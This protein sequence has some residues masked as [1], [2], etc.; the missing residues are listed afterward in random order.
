MGE[1]R[2]DKRRERDAQSV[3]SGFLAIRDSRWRLQAVLLT[4]GC[5]ANDS[6]ASMFS[7]ALPTIKS[8][9][10][11]VHTARIFCITHFMIFIARVERRGWKILKGVNTL[12]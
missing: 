9:G 5:F 8:M 11:F 4:T 7:A 10:S 12:I 1:V 6:Q 3:L 2:C